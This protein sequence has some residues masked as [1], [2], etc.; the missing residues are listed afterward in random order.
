MLLIAILLILLGNIF[1]IFSVLLFTAHISFKNK[2]ST[3]R[4]VIAN[5]KAQSIKLTLLYGEVFQKVS[6]DFLK[7]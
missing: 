7:I 3:T 4:E 1:L 2:L 5:L 6:P